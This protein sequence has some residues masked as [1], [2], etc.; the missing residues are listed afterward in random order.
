MAGAALAGAVLCL[1]STASGQNGPAPGFEVVSNGAALEVRFHG[2]P[3]KS[4]RADDNQNALALDFNQPVDPA[5]FDHLNGALPGWITMAY[6]NYDNGVIRAARPVTFLTRPEVDGFSLRLEPR[7]AAA[8]QPAPFQ[9]APYQ[10]PGA[11]GSYPPPY[12]PQGGPPPGAQGAAPPI[13]FAPYEAY[14]A[15]R[16]YY[17]L[18]YA[19]HRG[20][21]GWAMAYGNAAMRA[22]S[23]A[24][25]GGE[26]HDFHNGDRVINSHGSFRVSLGAVAL[27]GSIYDTDARGPNVRTATG[28]VIAKS[29]NNQI[30]GSAGLGFALGGDSEITLEGLLGN[31]SAG[32]KLAAWQGSPDGFFSASLIYHAADLDTP[33]ALLD[34]GLKDE[35]SLGAGQRLGYGL[36]GS[37]KGHFDNYSLSGHRDI[38]QTAGWNANL[39]WDTEVGAGLFAGIAYDGQG[40]YRL[41]YDTLTGTAP[42]PYVPLSIR[43]MEDHAATASL[44]AALWDQVWFDAFGGYIYDRY[45]KSSGGLYG[46]SIRVTPAPGFEIEVGARH[47]NISLLQG[48][49]GGET[50]AGISLN[51]GFG[52][53]P[54]VNSF[55]LW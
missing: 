38:V 55:A 42:T 1:A 7:S 52:G 4:V 48:E 3:L 15:A 16:N 30:S 20:D 17:G 6:S 9:A 8:P 46:G 33:E 39:R 2:I 23:G 36:W 32:G 50:S 10:Q 35:V 24:G 5:I 40:D 49:L 28:T 11:P 21:P 41:H 54:R 27:L 43:N 53:L 44:S 19:V 45:A 29:E 18:E 12:P 22:D 26:Y 47:S 13:P 31:G 14:A 51:L 34:K 25:F 37:V